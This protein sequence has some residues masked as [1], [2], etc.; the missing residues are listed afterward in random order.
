MVWIVYKYTWCDSKYQ[1]SGTE[2]NATRF[3]EDLK[4]KK[5]IEFYRIGTDPESLKKGE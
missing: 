1:V 4:K 3:V 2:V 5:D